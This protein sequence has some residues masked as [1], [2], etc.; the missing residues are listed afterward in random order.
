MS[1]YKVDKENKYQSVAKIRDLDGYDFRPRNKASNVTISKVT[2]VDNLMIDK[3][4]SVKFDQTFRRL[5]SLAMRVLND[6]DASDDDVR[7]VL[8]EEKLIKEIL[9]NRYSKYLR[10][11][12]ELL[13]LKKL[14]VI[15]NEMR[16][17]QVAIKKKA[18]YLE[19][20]EKE[21]SKGRGR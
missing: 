20:L 8:D 6:D 5:I 1:N 15:E 3:I 10:R 13:F 16:M 4:L 19:E 14:K 2:I 11:E 18:I 12:K 9:Q 17:K 21:K 7:I